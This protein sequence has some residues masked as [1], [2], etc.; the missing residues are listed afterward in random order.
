ML[1]CLVFLFYI[2][3]AGLSSTAIISLLKRFS[4]KF[5]DFLENIPEDII[6]DLSD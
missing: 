1:E 3:V 5:N 6:S 2:G 4:P